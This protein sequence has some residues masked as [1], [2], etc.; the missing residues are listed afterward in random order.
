ME[1]DRISIQDYRALSSAWQCSSDKLEKVTTEDLKKLL[2]E[3]VLSEQAKRAIIDELKRREPNFSYA[4]V[5]PVQALEDEDKSY[6]AL[7]IIAGI[8]KLFGWVLIIVGILALVLF[9]SKEMTLVGIIALAVALFFALFSFA[10]AESIVVI[11]DI[12]SS[13]F[14]I[15]KQ[16]SS[17]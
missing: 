16:V 8:F 6:P 14:R 15:L 2:A 4:S 17:K 12:S 7:A 3:Y 10:G 11:T 5:N 13:A 1:N 9:I